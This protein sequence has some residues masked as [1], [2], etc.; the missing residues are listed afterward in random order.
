VD[1]PGVVDYA[2]RTQMICVALE[3]LRFVD[4]IIMLLAM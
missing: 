3:L 1:E 2:K 4:W